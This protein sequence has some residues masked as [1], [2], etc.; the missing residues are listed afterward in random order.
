[1][2]VREE[3]SRQRVE[4]EQRLSVPEQKEGHCGQNIE[5]EGKRVKNVAAKASRQAGR[6]LLMKGL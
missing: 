2:K 1:M 3:H 6:G 4:L 5:G